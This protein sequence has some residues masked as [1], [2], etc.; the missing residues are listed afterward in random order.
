[1][2]IYQNGYKRPVTD[3]EYREALIELTQ[4]EAWRRLCTEKHPTAHHV[5]QAI[6]GLS[7]DAP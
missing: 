6:A 4:G 2:K 5:I 3:A 1:M 7:P